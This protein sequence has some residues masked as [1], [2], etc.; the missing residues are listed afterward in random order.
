MKEANF[1]RK[2]KF[3][4]I[5]SWSR[6]VYKDNKGKLWKDVN[7]GS[8]TPHLHSSTNNDFDG[9]PDSPI[10]GEYTIIDEYKEDPYSFDYAMLSMMKSRCDYFLGNGNRNPGHL[11]YDTA[12]EHI[13]A[14]KQRWN[15][16]PNDAKPEWLTWEQI[17][18][19]E[20]E[21]LNLDER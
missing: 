7:L 6:P 19:Y 21:M 13:A 14:M 1:M 2:L 8:G 5:D 4:D 20:K 18:Q 3:I 11:S 12:A 16:F 9:E 17:L 15:D 10:K